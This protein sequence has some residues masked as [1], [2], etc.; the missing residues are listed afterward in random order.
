MELTDEIII[1]IC[2]IRDDLGLLEYEI[3]MA[4]I[5]GKDM[6]K[7]YIDD[8]ILIEY[9]YGIK[10]GKTSSQMREICLPKY[11]RRELSK[12]LL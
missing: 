9:Y 2:E 1:K 3:G 10:G 6:P 7:R 11:I 5:D 4:A 8:D 12:N